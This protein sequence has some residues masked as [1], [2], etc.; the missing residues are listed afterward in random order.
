MAFTITEA[1]AVDTT[2]NGK[3]KK[4]DDNAISRHLSNNVTQADLEGESKAYDVE[5][6]RAIQGDA[7]FH[8]LSWRRLTVV[9]IVEAIALGSLSLPAAFATLGMVAGVILCVGV[10]LVAMYASYILGKVKLKYPEVAHYADIGRL[11]MGGVGSKLFSIIFAS[12][13]IL[14]TGSHCLTGT[15]AFETITGSGVCSLAFGVVSAIILFLLAIPPSFTEAAILGYIDFAS[16]IIAIG[17][18]MIATGIQSSSQ[19]GGLGASTWS[20]WPQKDLT[21][22][23]AIVAV[24]SIVFAYAFAGAQPSFMDEMHTPKDYIKSIWWLGIIEVVIYTVTGAVIYAFVGQDVQSPALLSA[25]S[26]VS[27]VAFGV[28]LPVIFISGSINTTV[29]ARFIHGRIYRNSITRY[30]NTVRGWVSWLVVVGLVTLVAWIIAEA[31]PFFS[32]LL[33]ISSSLFVSGLSFY[34]PPVM[35]YV[36]LKEGKWY[37]RKNWKTAF[38]NGSVFIIGMI[39]LVCGTYASIVELIHKFQRHAVNRPFTCQSLA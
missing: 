33:S 30:V 31:I 13:L 20:A 37:E 8:R 24:N 21:F 19:P 15:V 6:Q 11:M 18:T 28:A 5:T 39:I 35:W 10:G 22:S 23:E 9:L 7:H 32:E 14:V 1:D 17:I 26:V 12:Q 27:R 3:D 38:F 29:V 4:I 16:I 25:G 36:L 2:S 34:L